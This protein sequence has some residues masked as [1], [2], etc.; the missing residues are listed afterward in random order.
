L[1]PAADVRNTESNVKVPVFIISFNRLHC[2]QQLVAWLESAELAEPIIIDNGSSYPPLLEWF[3]QMRNTIAIRDFK[4]NYGPYRIWEQRLF[5][6][7]TTPDQPFYVVTDPDVIPIPECPKDAIPRLIDTC[8][9]LRSP[10]VG[11]SLRLETIPETLPTGQEIRA[12]ETTLQSQGIGPSGAVGARPLPACY[13]SLLDTTFQVN[14][15]DDVPLSY[16]SPGIRLAHPYQA[17]HLGWNLDPERLSEEEKFYWET[18]SHRASTIQVLKG[19][20]FSG[21]R[22]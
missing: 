16:G 13:G 6:P 15:R 21:K 7:H 18:A 19:R 10:K 1:T 5:A 9:A 20:G 2:L 3:E 17:D 12:W 14:H 11:L 8:N 4:D 22:D